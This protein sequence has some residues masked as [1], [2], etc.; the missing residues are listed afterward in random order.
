MQCDKI[1]QACGRAIDVHFTKLQKPQPLMRRITSTPSMTIQLAKFQRK[2]DV[3]LFVPFGLRWVVGALMVHDGVINL[4]TYMQISD[5]T[6]I[7]QEDR[8]F[9]ELTDFNTPFPVK[10]EIFPTVPISTPLELKAWKNEEFLI[11]L[12]IV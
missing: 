1:F 2:F 11:Y 4:I 9:L 8:N 5:S 6:S 7:K 10:R 3:F 12:T